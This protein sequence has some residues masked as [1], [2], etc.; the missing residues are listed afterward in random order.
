MKGTAAEV[1][2][3]FGDGTAASALRHREAFREHDATLFEQ[4]GCDVAPLWFQR[5][6]T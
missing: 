5:L 4:V 6:E 2:A 1:R 3:G